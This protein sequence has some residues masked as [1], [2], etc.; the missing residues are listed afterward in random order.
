[1][2]IKVYKE[3]VP[4]AQ[5]SG[6]LEVVIDGTKW[7]F[8]KRALVTGGYV[9]WDDVGFGPWNINKWP[10]GFPEELKE[11]TLKAVNE[12]VKWGCCGGCV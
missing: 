5:C 12:Q 9:V 8:P 4:Y 6:D 2:E 7:K 3:D 11:A 1:M 10:D